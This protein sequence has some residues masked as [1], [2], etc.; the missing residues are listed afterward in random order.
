MDYFVG[1]IKITKIQTR[2][3]QHEDSKSEFW[4]FAQAQMIVFTFITGLIITTS[5]MDLTIL[6]MA[7]MI[8]TLLAVNS[9]RYRQFKRELAVIRAELHYLYIAMA[10]SRHLETKIPDA[11]NNY[12][13]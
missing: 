13:N 7:I 3:S 9:H 8:P 12:V 5:S 11:M 6:W 4:L 10:L 1:L 2:F